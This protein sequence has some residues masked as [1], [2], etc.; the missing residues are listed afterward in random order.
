MASAHR[1]RFSP[2]FESRWPHSRSTIGGRSERETQIRRCADLGGLTPLRSPDR[3]GE[4]CGVS[5]PSAISPAFKSRLPHSRLVIGGRSERETQ[6]RR[7]ADLGGL[8]PLRSPGRKGERCG[9][10]PPSAILPA[11]ESRLPH[12]RSVIGGRSERNRRCA[13]LGGLTPLRSPGRKGERCGVS[14]PSAILPELE[15]PDCR[16]ADRLLEGDRNG[17]RRFAGARTSEG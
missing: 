8:T 16:S 13:D 2:V 7:C 12:S 10:S 6:I 15:S 1:V 17:K 4:R 9:V 5:P 3:K 11:F 14:P